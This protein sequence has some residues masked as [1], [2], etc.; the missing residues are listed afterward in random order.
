[1]KHLHILAILSIITL[2]TGC[3]DD[4]LVDRKEDKLIGTWEFEK[5]FYRRDGDLF[6]DNVTLD[7]RDDVIV[8]FG[9]YSAEYFDYSQCCCFDYFEQACCSDYY[10][11]YCSGY[12]DRK[13][14]RQQTQTS[15]SSATRRKL[16]GPEMVGASL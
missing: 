1:M 4:Y 10:F 2:A 16:S 7:Y 5:A 6:R 15:K 11:D 12:F 13:K 14:P 3:S 9:D 8:F